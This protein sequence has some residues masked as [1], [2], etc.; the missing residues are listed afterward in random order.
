MKTY[1]QSKKKKPSFVFFSGFSFSEN[2]W[3]N[4]TTFFSEFEYIILSE[5]YFKTAS[6]LANEQ[7]CMSF[8]KFFD[9]EKQYIGIGH[10]LGFQKISNI[11]KTFPDNFKGIVG[12]NAFLNFTS[13]DAGYK[14]TC[15]KH[16]NE[17]SQALKVDAN[18]M[19]KEFRAH[20]GGDFFIETKYQFIDNNILARDLELLQ[21][22]YIIADFPH[23]ILGSDDDQI[24]PKEIID[25]DFA[26]LKNTN[27]QYTDNAGHLLGYKKPIWVYKEIMEFVRDIGICV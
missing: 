4:L 27:V 16:I 18:L 20:L 5:N 13:D 1:N 9:K 19:I 17:M 10:S 14:K 22:T 11:A 21:Q 8:E 3:I 24:T 6:Q 23:L 7:N 25:A 12:L 26:N 2:F 15:L